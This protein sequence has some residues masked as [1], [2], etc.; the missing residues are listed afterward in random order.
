MYVDLPLLVGVVLCGRSN[1]SGKSCVGVLFFLFFFIL[2]YIMAE[3]SVMERVGLSSD[4]SLVHVS[5]YYLY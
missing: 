1:R 5:C 4:Q 3:V 2:L